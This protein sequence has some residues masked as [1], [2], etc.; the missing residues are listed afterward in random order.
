MPPR[1]RTPRARWRRTSPTDAN[2]PGYV[3]QVCGELDFLT[4]DQVRA[5]I[6]DLVDRHR[7]VTVDLTGATV[8]DQ[9]ALGA[10]AEARVRA[11]RA[12]C[13]LAFTNGPAAL[14]ALTAAQAKVRRV[15]R[16]RARR[17]RTT[18]PTTTT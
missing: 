8:Y 16:P 17:T 2:A 10:P 14:A 7:Q 13:H 5:R 3:L 1:T 12:G 9:A 11:H 15:R 6:Q 4:A 18:L